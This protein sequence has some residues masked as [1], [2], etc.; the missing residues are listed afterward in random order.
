M[1]TRTCQPMLTSSLRTAVSELT[2]TLSGNFPGISE[3]TGS[4]FFMGRL[5]LSLQKQLIHDRKTYLIHYA[6]TQTLLSVGKV[7]VTRCCRQ[8]R[9][10]SWFS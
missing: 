10:C 2:A 4:H 8:N 6:I 3:T 5:I 1:K 9:L 7:I